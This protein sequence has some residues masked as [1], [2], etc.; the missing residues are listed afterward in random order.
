MASKLL[1][2]VVA[3]SVL[4]L[5]L[6]GSSV[7]GAQGPP[8]KVP[9]LIGFKALPGPA[10]E[11]LVRS[12]GGTIKHRYHLVRA[13]AA[14]VP[15]QAIEGLKKNPKVTRVDPD[16]EVH[17]IDAE[18]DNT[19]GVKRIGAGIV[20]D[21]GNRGSGVKVAIID[22]GVDYTHPDL[23]ANFD[24]D[25]QKRGYDFVNNDSDPMDDN[26]HGTH[27]AGSE[28][29]ED[30][31]EG[32]VGV[33]PEARL[34][35]LKVLN[36]GGGG[37]YSDVIA[38][39]QW[40]VD[41]GIQVTNNS[42]GSS[43]DPGPIVKA[44][45]DN[46]YAAG[47]LNVAAAGN[48]GNCAGT[49]DSVIYPAR[50]DS[51]IAVAATNISDGVPCFSSTGPD[52][53]LAAPGV[54]VNSTL[55]GGGYGTKSGTS[56]ASPHM[57]GTAALVL[58]SG[59]LTDQDGDGD[60]DNV[61]V[62]LKLQ[63]TAEDL[64]LPATWVGYGLVDADGAVGS[65]APPPPPPP[66]T[67][68]AFD[69]FESE[70]W[71][72]GTGWLDSW[73]TSGD[74]RLRD[75]DSPHSGSFHVRLRRSTGYF[76]RS[77]DLSGQ[78][79]VHLRFWSKVRSFENS[80]QANVR[81][82]SDGSNWTVVKTFTS[83]DS[84]NT[85]H[86]Y[87]I[88]LSSVTMSSRFYVAFDAEMSSRGDYWFVDDVELVDT[89]PQ[90]AAPTADAQSVSTAEDT[91]TGLTLTGSDPDLDPL[92]FSVAAG[93]ANGTISG[94]PP[95]L[96]YMPNADFN[97][98]DSFTFTVNDSTVD[99]APATVNITV[100]A[101]NDPPVAAVPIAD[102]TVAEDAPDTAL[103]LA[104]NFTD[105]DI[106][107]N[108]DSLTYSVTDN[109][110]PGLVTAF[111][112][113]PVLTLSYAGNQSGVANITVRA[114]DTSAAYAED[115]F[116]VTVTPVNDAPSATGDSYSTDEDVALSVVAPGVLGNDGDI[117]NDPLT[118]VLVGGVS[119]GTLTLSAD[120]SFTYTPSADFNGSDS[121]TYKANDG[122]LD[123]NAVTVMI[124]VVA[125]NDAP[126][127]GHDTANTS[128]AISVNIDV[129]S[130]DTDVD[131]AT[132]SDSLLVVAAT[133]PA[134]GTVVN[135]AD[136]T[137]TYTPNTGF[138]G[139]DTF[140]Y[141]IEDSGALQD[142]AS[143]TVTV[144]ANA[145]PAANADSATVGEGGSVTV[146]DSSTTSVLTNDS[147][148]DG[149][150]L[151]A[152]LVADVS[153]G[154]L[155]LNSDGTFSY[156]HDGS[157]TTSDSFTYKARDTFNNDSNVATVSITVNPVNDAPS[158]TGDSYGT[159]EDV[160]LNVAAPGVLGNDSDPEDNS[161]TVILV[162]DVSN[163]VLTL[164]SDG[165]FAYTPSADFNGSDSFTYKASD[166]VADSN[167]ATVNITISAVNDAPVAADVGYSVDQDTTLG[168]TAP[169]VL[170]NDTDVDGGSL[171][172]VLVSGTSNGSVT[173]NADGSFLYTPNA[174]FNG[175][176]SFTYTAN[177]GTVDS[178]NA[179]VS[180]T[181]NPVNDAPADVVTIIKAEYD[182]GKARLKIEA[183]STAGGSVTLTATAFDSNGNVLG[184]TQM[185]Y[186][187]E[188]DRYKGKI[189]KF[190][191]EPFRVEV[192][193]TGGG[194]DIVEGSGIKF[195]GGKD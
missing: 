141:T 102:V 68:T 129:L 31:N 183:T 119:S 20:H 79:G 125:V 60:V 29:A 52:V 193:S 44:A 158:A 144:S 16:I 175:S 127:A 142:T 100:T 140:I 113:S 30:N 71:S 84:D 106:A 14:S 105:A 5:A 47:V 41:N 12:A 160:A 126:V 176:D 75:S 191:S 188:K 159:D 26:G 146:L 57:A 21:G 76:E 62:R 81:V 190:T 23:D 83:A 49:G 18:L 8:D 166:G 61:D 37:F 66:G 170:S 132:N 122:A 118:A 194:S 123:S 73:S 150:P 51:V 38:A 45:F 55:L 131:I 116:V 114:M 167:Q 92:T 35:A 59:N 162:S 133:T 4:V 169:G 182:S 64:G 56:M 178:N 171:T 43:G 58:T 135:E 151:T 101:V 82:S 99:S 145:A 187:A 22:S 154:T 67:K 153:H 15:Q 80:D 1:Q 90:N 124:D 179:T 46:S 72:G 25:P 3:V 34:Y 36:A 86:P 98:S 85:Y 95:N 137:I 39:L 7:V 184:S 168:V 77:V 91:A 108:G 53:E 63:N 74:V 11:D 107:T 10:D 138:L 192:T 152:I 185:E 65:G 165:S 9:V 13:V 97:G 174:G 2:I 121:F 189:T 149:D 17:A 32:V 134:N 89:G 161:L 157:E 104:D 96:T 24:P 78:G 28:G 136:N 147:D 27:V 109:D 40:A 120:G 94:T 48:G 88:D 180:I 155:M 111:L 33:A 54:A 115:T 128:E 50:W 117:E 186:N 181:V 164:N 87:D 6:G 112:S 130:N 42:Y 143:V 148:P 177:D 139:D 70:S 103:D 163:G 19:W 172:V 110:N 93:P 195:K 173:L 156:T 69:D